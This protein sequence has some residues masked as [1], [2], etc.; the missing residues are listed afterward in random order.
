MCTRVIIMMLLATAN[1]AVH[2]KMLKFGSIII[3]LV[4]STDGTAR[5]GPAGNPF[6]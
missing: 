5:T 4:T 1:S 3:V 6:P 2:W